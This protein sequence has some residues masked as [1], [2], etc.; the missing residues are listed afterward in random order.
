MI[1]FKNTAVNYVVVECTRLR[2]A[3]WYVP[4]AIVSLC[5]RKFHD[6]GSLY[7]GKYCTFVYETLFPPINQIELYPR[8]Q[9]RTYKSITV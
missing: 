5:R 2:G 1:L 7:L 9:S 4:L 8:K 3:A 6:F